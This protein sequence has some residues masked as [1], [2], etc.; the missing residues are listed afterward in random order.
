MKWATDNPSML[1]V[2]EKNKLVFIKDGVE[3]EPIPVQGSILEFND[4]KVKSVFLDEI[5]ANPI[6]N[7]S[8][9]TCEG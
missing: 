7:M 6:V 8:E 4:L 9:C 2:L 5:A 3:E 1:C